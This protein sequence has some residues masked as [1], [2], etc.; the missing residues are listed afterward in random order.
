MCVL[1]IVVIYDEGLGDIK[2]F[3][4]KR[5]DFK[6]LKEAKLFFPLFKYNF[7]L[8]SLNDEA[9]SECYVFSFIIFF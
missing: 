7:R 8:Y 5:L 6:H 1:V 2:Y 4:Q 3:L 9:I